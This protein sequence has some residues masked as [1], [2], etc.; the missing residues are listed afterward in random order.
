VQD[1]NAWEAGEVINTFLEKHFLHPLAPEERETIKTYFLKPASS[2]LAVP[3]L[4]DDIKE[5]IKKAGESPHFGA[6]RSLF[7][8]QEQ[9]LEMARP[10]TCLWSD[11]LS[12]KATVKQEDVLLL[13]QSVL[14]KLGSV[15][16]T[17]TQERRRIAWG[18]VNPANTLPDE[19]E[20]ER[21]VTLFGGGFL[22][23]VS[24]KP[25]NYIRLW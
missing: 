12:R 2:A 21:E 22:E 5:Q 7:K 1:E 9:I 17:I 15:S 23:S 24:R 8:L 13:L 16:H 18:R 19:P 25:K 4:D 6:E 11:I 14:M 10:L 3:K 20:E